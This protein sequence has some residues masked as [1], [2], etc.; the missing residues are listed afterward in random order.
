MAR[1]PLSGRRRRDAA[2]AGAAPASAL[3][4]GGS[5][6]A[7][8]RRAATLADGW[9]P[10]GTPR[11][12]LPAQIARLR[13]LRGGAPA[14]VGANAEPLYVGT[15]SWDVGRHTRTGTAQEHA[16][17]LREFAVMGANHIQVRLRG[18][19]CDELC[20]QIAAFGA[21]VAPHLSA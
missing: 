9:M 17:S 14:D 19:S 18:R 15:P 5:S 7:A 1:P 4:V 10:Q 6:P 2:P 8:V 3:W 13:E 21:E 16:A 12:A 20:D 11:A